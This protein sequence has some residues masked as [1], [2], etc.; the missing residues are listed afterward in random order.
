ME[1][2]DLGKI[3]SYLTKKIIKSFRPDLKIN[4]I[5]FLRAPFKTHCTQNVSDFINKYENED[6][7]NCILDSETFFRAQLISVDAFWLSQAKLESAMDF[8]LSNSNL[9]CDIHNAC[10]PVI[11]S[12][13]NQN[14]PKHKILINSSVKKIENI[15]SD[16]R[17]EIAKQYSSIPGE[18]VVIC[19]PKILVK[20]P[21]TNPSY[22]CMG[23]GIPFPNANEAV[24]DITLLEELQQDKIPTNRKDIE[25][26]P[27]STIQYRLIA[28]LLT[29]KNGIRIF[30]VDALSKDLKKHYKQPIKALV[31][32]IFA[33]SK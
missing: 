13:L 21:L 22:R 1:R 7:G 3:F 9:S 18:L 25:I 4:L 28:S 2:K 31:D 15:I 16:F 33:A 11:A 12:C 29:P 20:N 10:K 30:G 8:F 26:S 5:E 19:I 24:Q 14:T 32:E 23:L 27:H 17:K 6:E